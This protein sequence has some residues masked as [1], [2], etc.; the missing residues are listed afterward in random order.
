MRSN[1]KDLEWYDDNS[2]AK[3]KAL[4]RSL[5]ASARKCVA[6]SSVHSG[7]LHLDGVH[8]RFYSF[9][10]YIGYIPCPMSNLHALI[11]FHMQTLHSYK[12]RMALLKAWISMTISSA[13]RS[14]SV[15]MHF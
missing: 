3:S 9:D 4:L 15:S 12:S 10:L 1:C 6:D 14:R 2:Q 7:Q 11:L 5:V 13:Y 8:I